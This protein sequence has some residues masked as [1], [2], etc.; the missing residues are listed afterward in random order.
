MRGCIA[1]TSH[2]CC[3]DVIVSLVSQWSS[4]LV[5]S[6]RRGLARRSLLGAR[7]LS[8][9]QKKNV[10]GSRLPDVL[11]Q[12][13]APDAETTGSAS[14]LEASFAHRDLIP[15]PRRMQ[16]GSKRG[17]LGK[18]LGMPEMR[19]RC[20]SSSFKRVGS[21]K[22]AFSCQVVVQDMMRLCLLATALRLW[23]WM[24]L[25]PRFASVRGFERCGSSLLHRQ[26]FFFGILSLQSVQNDRVMRQLSPR[27]LSFR[28]EDF[29][30]WAPAR[31]F[32]LIWDYTFLCALPPSL[33]P[34]WAKSMR[35]LVAPRGVLA[36]L[37]FP[38]GDYKGGPPYA[39][40]PDKCVA[41]SMERR[42]IGGE[43][44]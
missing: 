39:L 5:C 41:N 32:D 21:R 1:I 16:I 14:I 28:E 15:F 19:P 18:P 29:F 40:Q 22:G 30:R 42:G 10:F 13:D 3:S 9:E 36:T 37:L 8:S 35:R 31:P 17:L 2:S 12:K 24:W 4:R 33:W 23:V 25:Q 7:F 34:R 6:S 44:E 26:G 43:W 20:S 11:G 27:Q 38:V